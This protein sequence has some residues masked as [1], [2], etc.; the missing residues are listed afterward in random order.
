VAQGQASTIY[1]S[2]ASINPDGTRVDRT[3][4]K[5]PYTTGTEINID[6]G[7]LAASAAAA[8]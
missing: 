7:I 6:G 8:G 4:D 1:R 5:A 2:V 3:S